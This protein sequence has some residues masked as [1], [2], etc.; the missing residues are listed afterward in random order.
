M[1]EPQIVLNKAYHSSPIEDPIDPHIPIIDAHHH[2]FDHP[3]WRYLPEDFRE[4]LATAGNVVGSVFVQ[5]SWG[6][7]E[8]GPAALRPV[9]ETEWVE[10]LA[11]LCGDAGDERRICA[12]IVGFADLQ[13]GAAVDAVLEAHL[14][15][16]PTRFR[17]IRHVAAWDADPVY[18]EPTNAAAPGL[19]LDARFQQGFARLARYGLTYDCWIFSPQLPD[20]IALARRFPDTTIVLDHLGTPPGIGSYEAKRPAV[21]EAWQRDIR[22]LAKCPNVVVKIGGMG[23]PFAGFGW[24]MRPD[25]PT[26]LDLAEQWRPLFEV[27]IDAFS[28]ARCMFESNAPVDKLTG[29]YSVVWNSFK[30]LSADLSESE[31]ADLFSG[32]AARTYRLDIPQRTA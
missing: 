20:V 15:A 5:G 17:G 12:G 26:S 27:C 10:S 21:L 14:A 6:Y 30:R 3:G 11:A 2:L 28:P 4:D 8:E 16:A 23:E 29:S 18:H 19:L 7:R 13:L 31:R 32:T 25:R 9:G 24:L 22:E 1:G